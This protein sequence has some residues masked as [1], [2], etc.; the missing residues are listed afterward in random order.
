MAVRF[1]AALYL[2]GR[3]LALISV[4]DW[5]DTMAIMPLEGL[6]QLKNIT[7]PGLEPATFRLI[8]KCLNQLRYSVPQ[9]GKVLI[10]K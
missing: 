9:H 10:S 3:I 5:V 2:P 6:G 1:S 8:A 4:R 7:S